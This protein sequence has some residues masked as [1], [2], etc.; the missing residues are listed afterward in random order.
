MGIPSQAEYERNERTRAYN[1]EQRINRAPLGDR[2]AARDAFHEA[3]AEDP[4]TVAERISWLLDGNYGYG[5]MQAAK[6]VVA[7]KR[8]NREAILTQLVAVHEWQCPRDMA[9]AAWTKLT[10]AQKKAL[11]AAVAVVVQHAEAGEE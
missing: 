8:L 5:Q 7:N 6:E 9:R 10:P 3:M 1:D 4:A 11:S 2:K